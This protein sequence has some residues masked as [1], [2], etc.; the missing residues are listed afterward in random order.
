MCKS[1]AANWSGAE[2]EPEQEIRRGWAVAT[3]KVVLAPDS[4]KESLSS[5]EVA[6]AMARGVRRACPDAQIDSV[7]MADGGEGTVEALVSATGGVYCRRMVHDPLGR[8]VQASFALLGKGQWAVIEMAEASGLGLLKP[9]E[10]NPL[11]TSTRGTGELILAALEAGVQRII[12]GIGGSATVDGGTGMAR[13][14]GVRFL[15]GAG[16]ELPEGGGSLGKL[17]T[18]DASELDKRVKDVRIEVASD[19]NNPLVGQ[20]GASRI[21]GPQKGATPAMV[22]QLE[23]GLARLAEKMAEQL[24]QDIKGVPGAGAAGGLG[25]GLVGFLAGRLRSGVELVIEAVGLADRLAGAQ[26]CIT[27]EGKLD[28]QTAHGKTVAGVGRLARRLK[29]PAVALAGQIGPGAQQVL[30]EGIVEYLA[31]KP[32]S[33]SVQESMA[34][35]PELLAD[36]AEEVVRRFIANSESG[37]KR[38][39]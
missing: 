33:M 31:I 4:F 22:E 13:A 21:F 26:L 19:V 29:V 20:R 24:G 7:P 34:R 38:L 2:C 32:E 5:V 6:R 14:L 39:L 12:V 23:A 27:G 28:S 36:A 35:A 17:E 37:E 11:L 16:N 10:R 9:K 15:D 3:L 1:G 8:E 18:I 30:S 25:A